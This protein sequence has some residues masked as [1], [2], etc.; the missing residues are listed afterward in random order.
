[1]KPAKLNEIEENVIKMT[2]N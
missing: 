2:K 1:M